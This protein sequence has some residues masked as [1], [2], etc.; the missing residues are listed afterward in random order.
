VLGGNGSDPVESGLIGSTYS[1]IAGSP[2]ASKS[3][4]LCHQ[5]EPNQYSGVEAMRARRTRKRVLA[6]AAVLLGAAAFLLPRLFRVSKSLS[7]GGVLTP[8]AQ[9]MAAALLLA[10]LIM[11]TLDPD[12]ALRWGRIVGM[13]PV[14]GMLVLMGLQGPGNLWPVAMLLALL[15]GH[16]RS[17]G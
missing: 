5:Q 13:G 14:L 7:S 1:F 10:G 11:G 9:V 12:Q 15:P 8:E 6:S 16:A 17:K 4:E 2:P 3:S